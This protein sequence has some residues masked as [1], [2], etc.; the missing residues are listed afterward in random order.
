MWGKFWCARGEE[1]LVVYAAEYV[2]CV[3]VDL[4]IYDLG[5]VGAADV[6]EGV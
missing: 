4:N 6:D 5:V 3:W 2:V 1:E